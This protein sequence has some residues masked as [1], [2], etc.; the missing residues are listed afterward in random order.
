[1]SSCVSGLHIHSA[2]DIC[3]PVGSTAH[4]S[5]PHTCSREYTWTLNKKP[6]QIKRDQKKYS[7]ATSQKNCSLTIKNLKKMDRGTYRYCEIN[8][9]DDDD[10]CKKHC[11]NTLYVTGKDYF[12]TFD[13]SLSSLYT[14]QSCD[15]VR[16]LLVES[17]K[18]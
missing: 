6:I 5:C 9:D 2:D 16:A 8:D 4:L 17:V 18:M 7:L 15:K 3:A 12:I 10:D 14:V 13:L 11:K 1:M